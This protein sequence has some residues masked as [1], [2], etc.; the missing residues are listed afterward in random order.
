MSPNLAYVFFTHFRVKR[1]GRS[2][3]FKPFW[4]NR[5][6]VFPLKDNPQLLQI[7]L[8]GHFSDHH[9]GVLLGQ[10]LHLASPLP[11]VEWMKGTLQTDSKPLSACVLVY[12][13]AG[14]QLTYYLESVFNLLSGNVP[15]KDKVRL[16]REQL[17]LS[18]CLLLCAHSMWV[19][20]I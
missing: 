8:G 16:W 14:T 7:W 9:Y 11:R 20:W 17:K 19:I 1:P 15:H 3:T 5:L 6:L 10:F 4:L 12:H 13:S 2:Q 18:S